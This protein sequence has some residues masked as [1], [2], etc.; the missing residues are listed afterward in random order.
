MGPVPFGR[1]Q[2]WSWGILNIWLRYIPT[3]N[4]ET[5]NVSNRTCV[6]V[7]NQTL[8]KFGTFASAKT[9]TDLLSALWYSQ[10]CWTFAV[11]GCAGMPWLTHHLGL[12]KKK[13]SHTFNSFWALVIKNKMACLF[14]LT[15]ACL[16]EPK[17]T[18]GLARPFLYLK[19]FTIKGCVNILFAGRWTKTRV[20]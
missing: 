2:T 10:Q 1:A 8:W 4:V 5:L 18:G 19:T 9:S 7:I 14:V 16:K 11:S 3:G 12:L 20:G 13:L 17:H 6:S 15:W